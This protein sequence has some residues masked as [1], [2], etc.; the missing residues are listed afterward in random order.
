[1]S[2]RAKVVRVEPSATDEHAG[3]FV[4]ESDSFVF[5]E[6]ENPAGEA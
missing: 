5:N 1:M 3:G 2:G 4:A 6:G